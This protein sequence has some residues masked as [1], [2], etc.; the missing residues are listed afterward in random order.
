MTDRALIV[1]AVLLLLC[2]CRTQYVPIETV[3]KEYVHSTDTVSVTDTV[4]NEK[5]IIVRPAT[6]ADSARL[7]RLGLQLDMKDNYILVLE[8]ELER[9]SHDKLHSKTDTVYRD[10]EVQVPY[11]VERK[12]TKWEQ[13]CVNYGKIMISI[14]VF[15]IVAAIV[16]IIVYIKRKII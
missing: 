14:T 8:R 11:P 6:M 13:I 1:V 4:T 5:E 12:L 16:F 9:K 7:T 2:G 10:R 15:C 3:V